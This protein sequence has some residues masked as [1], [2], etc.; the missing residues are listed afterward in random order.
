MILVIYTAEKVAFISLC[1]AASKVHNFRIVSA[2]VK[3]CLVRQKRGVN[4]SPLKLESCTV[5]GF[6]WS[7]AHIVDPA[8]LN[9]GFH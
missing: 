6:T 8:C 4:E 5:N 7:C 1:S 3:L 9:G 2:Y